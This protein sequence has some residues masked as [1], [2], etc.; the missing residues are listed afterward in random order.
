MDAFNNIDE[1]GK[2]LTDIYNTIEAK[3]QITHCID[4]SSLEYFSCSI[5]NAMFNY[6][7]VNLNEENENSPYIDLI[8]EANRIG[9]QVTAENPTTKKLE[10]SV[11][12]F[13]SYKIDRLIVFF[14]STS[15][16]NRIKST[17][18]EEIWTLPKIHEYLKKK[19]DINARI[20]KELKIWSGGSN[21][22]PS[23]IIPNI[24]K[25]TTELISE[26]EKLKKYDPSLLVND[27]E[28]ENKSM[29]FLGTDYCRFVFNSYKN[30]FFDSQ[31]GKFLCD[32]DD[33]EEK[34][35]NFY[36]YSDGFF[37]TTSNLLEERKKAIFRKYYESDENKKKKDYFQL[38]NNYTYS[39]FNEIISSSQS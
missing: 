19:P 2:L 5:F 25:N 23:E 35:F 7:L 13:D 9:V 12:A 4:Y 27:C 20:I 3:R 24:N 22:L 39:I 21:I 16:A 32:H 11:Q 31:L 1:A 34:P 15:K 26:M 14:F 30:M 10:K 18:G 38:S 33:D 6:N 36:K 37:Q 17:R 28:D 8:D 29:L